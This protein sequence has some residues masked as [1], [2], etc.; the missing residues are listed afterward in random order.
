MK[1]WQACRA[2]S[3]ATT[4]YEPLIIGELRFSDGGLLHNNPV[5]LVHA[6]AGEMFKDAETLLISLG[7]GIASNTEYNP[8]IRTVASQLAKIA[9]RTQGDADT[10]I[11]SNG[12]KATRS[13][14]YFR[15][16]IPGIGDIGLDEADQLHRIKLASENYLNDPEIGM[17]ITSCSE[18]L[19]EGELILPETLSSEPILNDATGL[20][21]R[22]DRLRS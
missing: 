14:R 4:F 7:T 11:R 21:D 6:E 20:Q 8:N 13:K 10:F 18:Q 1:I 15:F 12:A 3:A 22:L 2:T 16:N 9:T 17:K 19:A 5:Q